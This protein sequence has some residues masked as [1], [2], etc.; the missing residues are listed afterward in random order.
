MMTVSETYFMTA[1]LVK[2]ML[3]TNRSNSVTE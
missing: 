1:L 3:L 2:R